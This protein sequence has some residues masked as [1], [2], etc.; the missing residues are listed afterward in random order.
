MSRLWIA[1]S[2]LPSSPPGLKICLL[3]SKS[4]QLKSAAVKTL[5]KIR[6]GHMS[7]ETSQLWGPVERLIADL[8]TSLVLT[9][10]LTANIAEIRMSSAE[11]DILMFLWVNASTSVAVLEHS[12]SNGLLSKS[13]SEIVV[14]CLFYWHYILKKVLQNVLHAKYHIRMLKQLSVRIRLPST[15]Q[16]NYVNLQRIHQTVIMCSNR[17]CVRTGWGGAAVQKQTQV[18]TSNEI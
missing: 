13:N 9:R 15:V 6:W 8:G 5:I 17:T 11:P 14:K 2:S 1:P 18:S 16:N 4:P 12:N 3:G 7:G 10:F